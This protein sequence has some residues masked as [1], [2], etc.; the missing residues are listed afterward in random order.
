MAAEEDKR[1]VATVGVGEEPLEL[2]NGDR[3][4]WR[5][6]AAGLADRAHGVGGDAALVN[7]D[8]QDP[9]EVDQRFAGGVGRA[10]VLGEVAL[11]AEDAGSVDVEQRVVE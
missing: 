3:P 7:G 8:L 10:A 6:G 5:A 4:N 11:V 9:A 1:A 2:L